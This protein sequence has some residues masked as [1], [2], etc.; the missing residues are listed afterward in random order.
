MKKLLHSPIALALI[1]A[2][3]IGIGII[4]YLKVYSDSPPQFRTEI[5]QRHNQPGDTGERRNTG[6]RH[7][8]KTLCGLQQQS[9]ERPD[10]AGTG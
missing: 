10:L 9:E 5:S 1:A 4:V 2:A 3:I 6:F 7:S 8:K